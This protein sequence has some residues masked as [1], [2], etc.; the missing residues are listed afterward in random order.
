MV[1]DLEDTYECVSSTF[2]SALWILQQLLLYSQEPTNKSAGGTQL[3]CSELYVKI[4]WSTHTPSQ[5]CG[6]GQECAPKVSTQHWTNRHFYCTCSFIGKQW[7]CVFLPR[8]W[9]MMKIHTATVYLDEFLN[10]KLKLT[11]TKQICKP[12]SWKDTCFLDVCHFSHFNGN[13][14]K[15]DIR[16]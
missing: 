16:I 3:I 12:Y 1:S 15:S 14:L 10:Y 6:R 2:L 13:I 11:E 8:F 5:T 4:D 9:S 7:K